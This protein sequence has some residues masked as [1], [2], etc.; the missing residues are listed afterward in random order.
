MT[1]ECKLAGRLSAA[2]E[3]VTFPSGDVVVMFRLIVARPD[4]SRVDTI[5]CR[6]DAGKLR[7]RALSLE[8]GTQIAV[9]GSLHR[10][11][12]RTAHGPASRYEV[13]VNALRKVR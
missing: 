13:L 2:A 11:F 10:R 5:D 7:V 3:E 12:W 1:N 6:V 8:A 9:E 4:E